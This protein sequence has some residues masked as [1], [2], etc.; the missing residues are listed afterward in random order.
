MTVRLAPRLFALDRSIRYVAVNQA[1]RITEMEQAADWPT[2]NPP[3]TDRM[4]ELVVNPV[5]L[6]AVK[7]RGDIDLGGV[8]HVIVRYGKQYQVVL[9]FE[10]GHVSVGVE[11]TGDVAGIAEKIGAALPA[12][13]DEPAAAVEPTPVVRALR[14]ALPRGFR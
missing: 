10:D 1:G 13:A 5:V 14:L 6:D 11:S 4:E 7:R 9:P 2:S 8:R 3:E 12:R